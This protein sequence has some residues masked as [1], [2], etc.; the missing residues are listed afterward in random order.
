[1]CSL[2]APCCTLLARRQVPQVQQQLS[3][4]ADAQCCVRVQEPLAWCAHVHVRWH[5]LGA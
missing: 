5:C 2:Q 1:M 3:K 4:S